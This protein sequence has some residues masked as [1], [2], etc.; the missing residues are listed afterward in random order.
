MLLAGSVLSLGPLSGLRTTYDYH[1]L[2]TARWSRKRY[3]GPPETVFCEANTK[4]TALTTSAP[5]QII[6]CSA[7]VNSGLTRAELP[8]DDGAESPYQNAVH[9]GLQ[10]SRIQR[11]RQARILQSPWV[12]GEQMTT[13]S[14]GVLAAPPTVTDGRVL[15]QN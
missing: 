15:P 2:G 12:K 4:E 9:I 10:H 7:I 1:G 13:E 11:D 6:L 3:R 14:R 5:W 8:I